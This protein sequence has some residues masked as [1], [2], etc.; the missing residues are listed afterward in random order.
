MMLQS[1][2][3]R[4]VRTQIYLDPELHRILKE[5]AREEGIS[6]AELLR[7]IARDYLRRELSRDDFFA[8][9]GLGES[10]AGNVSRDHDRHLAEALADDAG[11]R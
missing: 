7:R 10:G 6:L 4:K 8:I 5:K 1:P 2:A 3:M 9:V 11:L